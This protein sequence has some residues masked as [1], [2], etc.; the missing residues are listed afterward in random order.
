MKNTTLTLL[1]AV[2]ISTASISAYAQNTWK[3]SAK[4]AGFR[5]EDSMVEETL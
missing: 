1:T 3:D 4:D 5:N 2:A